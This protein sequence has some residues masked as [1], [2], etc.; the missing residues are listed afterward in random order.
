MENND[1]G[2]TLI[3]VYYDRV[4]MVQN[5]LRSIRDQ[6]YDNWHLVFID[7]GSK[8][9]GAPIV[10]EV[11][12][13]KIGEPSSCGYIAE[14]NFF[15]SQHEKATLYRVNDTPDEKRAQNGS[16]H[17]QFMTMG[18]LD[19]PR[20]DD[21]IVIICDDDALY[22]GYLRNLNE[23]YKARPGVNYS[24]CHLAPYEP[25]IEKPD[26]EQGKRTF[27]LNHG[28]DVPAAWCKV[29]STQVTYRKKIFTQYGVRYPSPAF[30]ALDAS[31]YAQLDRLGPTRF[32]G[33]IGQYKGSFPNQLSYRISEEDIY[34]PID[35]DDEVW[36]NVY[37]NGN[38]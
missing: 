8:T 33:I 26:P 9:P 25:H 11:L 18:V 37:N 2:I 13:D 32:N 35:I 19:T 31:L 16:R 29:D 12:G 36:K 38:L 22:P 15:F 17:P 7:D 1:L 5:A 24:Y 4:R 14:E 3:L 28:V 34:N 6:D 30:R 20:D 10:E 21:I 27:W 23:Y